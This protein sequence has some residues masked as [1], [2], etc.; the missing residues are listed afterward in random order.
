MVSLDRWLRTRYPVKS[1][2]ICTRKYAL[3]SATIICICSTLICCHYLT[4][5]F[6]DPDEKKYCDP[7][8]KQY[9]LYS[10]FMN[11]YWRIVYTCIQV[12]IPT[13]LMI[14]FLVH[15]FYIIKKTKQQTNVRRKQQF[16]QHQMFVLTL[17]AIFVHVLTA[18]PNGLYRILV[19]RHLVEYDDWHLFVVQTILSFIQSVNYASNFYLYC[20]TSP[21]FRREYLKIMCRKRVQRKVVPTV[22]LKSR[23]FCQSNSVSVKE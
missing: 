14:S 22:P 9:A 23:R 11:D 18:L 4:P 5:M 16:I 3:L 17:T 6:G 1:K 13:L 7:K 15:M 2:S 10:K 8:H 20:L 19:T 12:I 21:L